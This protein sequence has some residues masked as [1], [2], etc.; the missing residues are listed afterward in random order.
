MAGLR[1]VTDM[2]EDP[3]ASKGIIIA[4]LGPVGTE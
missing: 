1:E 2:V 4:R 3:E